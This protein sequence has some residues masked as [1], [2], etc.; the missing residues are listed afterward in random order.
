MN[1]RLKQPMGLLMAV[2][3][4][5]LLAE[6]GQA[7]RFR[8]PGAS[9]GQ[10]VV[11]H[12]LRLAEEIGLTPAQREQLEEL[13]I[14]ELESRQAAAARM[15]ELRSEVQAGLREPEALR[16]EMRASQ[17]AREGDRAQRRSQVM[18]I[19]S[20]E[21]REQLQSLARDGRRGRQFRRG[22]N[23]RRGPRGP[24]ARRGWNGGLP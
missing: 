3:A 22:Q 2:A 6:D 16:Q 24:G 5:T 1:L 21:Q 9:G 10:P 11:E 20:E 23:G 14:Q 7:Q 19:L 12:A 17:E 13:R 15:L 8:G 18:E 4:L